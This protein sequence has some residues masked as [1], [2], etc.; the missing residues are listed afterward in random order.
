VGTNFILRIKFEKFMNYIQGSLNFSNFIRKEISEFGVGQV[1]VVMAF[2][3]AIKFP[4]TF[5]IEKVKGEEPL[6]VYTIDMTDILTGSEISSGVAQKDYQFEKEELKNMIL[7]Y[8]IGGL[9]IDAL[10]AMLDERK[11]SIPMHQL[12]EFVRQQGG[13]N[14]NIV[15]FLKSLGI[16]DQL[17]TRIMSVGYGVQNG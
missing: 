3:T 16:Q 9:N 4:E 1:A 7:E 12:I 15:E 11:R 6:Y 5:L 10:F 8:D 13:A 17:I 14:E 2:Q